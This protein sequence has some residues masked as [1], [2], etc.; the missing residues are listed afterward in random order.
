MSRR[1][2]RQPKY[3]LLSGDG[4]LLMGSISK[5]VMGQIVVFVLL[6][7]VARSQQL[8]SNERELADSMLKQ[9]SSDVQHEYYD[10]KL[11]GLDW[12][13]LV[14]QARQR[15]AKAPD[16]T[17]ANADIAALLESLND[18]HTFFEPP[19]YLK[20]VDYGWKFQMFGERCYVTEVSSGSDA[21]KKGMNPGDEV[22]TIDGFEVE[23]DSI[24]RMQ[25]TMN[26]LVPTSGLR[27][28]LR[29]PAGKVER[30]DVASAVV[31]NEAVTGLGGSTI[32]TYWHRLGE[33][34]NWDRLRPQYKEL[35]PELMILQVPA[36]VQ[37]GLEVDE[38]FKKARN[39]KTLI[40]DLR[41]TPGGSVDS[42]LAYLGEVFDH[43]FKVS[44]LVTR[45]NTK[46][47]MVKGNRHEAFS[48]KL[49]VLIDSQSASAAEIFSRVVQLERRGTIL[50]DCSSGMVMEAQQF[51]HQLAS[52]VTYTYVDSI[53]VADMIMSDGKSLERTGVMPDKI[54]LPTATDLS[55]KLDSILSEA[56]REAG[57]ALS[58]E[59]AGKL[60]RKQ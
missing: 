14:L 12:N 51:L 43:D 28:E 58:P 34:K 39:H 22:F 23:R 47:L 5:S 21:E 36:F 56:A 29:K 37:T 49:I 32:D 25:Y 1:A 20:T 53:T 10:A 7:P 4:R 42:L 40:I 55:N 17:V 50:G 54:L 35:G 33:E 24:A 41:G 9:I 31:A 19:R 57:V 46:P 16:V 3:N 30:L 26:V 60:F 38:L 18:S 44:D 15:I 59:D 52:N 27:V 2:I 8:S 11:H 45:N 48:G 13:A 6:V